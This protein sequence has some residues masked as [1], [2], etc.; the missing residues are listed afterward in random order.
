VIGRKG[1]KGERRLNNAGGDRKGENTIKQ[2][3]G[4]LEKEKKK[5]S[6][7]WKYQ[8]GKGTV[9]KIPKKAARRGHGGQEVSRG[10]FSKAVN[11]TKDS[12]VWGGRH[13][14]NDGKSCCF[15][16]NE[17]ENLT[18]AFGPGIKKEGRVAARKV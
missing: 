17:M 12:C 1:K 4:K 11:Q 2:E 16:Q 8:G 13:G 18:R 14:K 15:K 10:F 7:R 6:G 9:N 5:P 3:A